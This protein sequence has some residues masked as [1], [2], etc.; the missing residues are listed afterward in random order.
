M[1]GKDADIQA[2]SKSI[3]QLQQKLEDAEKQR[4]LEVKE[5]ALKRTEAELKK[6]EEEKQQVKTQ[7]EAALKQEYHPPAPPEQRKINLPDEDKKKIARKWFDGTMP[8]KDK[9]MK[10]CQRLNLG[11][12][13]GSFVWRSED[14]WIHHFGEQLYLEGLVMLTQTYNIQSHHINVN[15]M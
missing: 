13:M 14:S 1:K 11:A 7:L 9:V 2:L 4:E 8:D 6:A 3:T 12:P 10:E 15:R 5:E